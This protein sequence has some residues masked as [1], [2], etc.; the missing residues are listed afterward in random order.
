MVFFWFKE[1]DFFHSSLNKSNRLHRTV[2]YAGCVSVETESWLIL[3]L[4]LIKVWALDCMSLRD[5]SNTK[6]EGFFLTLQTS[7]WNAQRFVLFDDLFLRTNVDI[8]ALNNSDAL[9]QTL[10]KVIESLH[11]YT[12]HR[13]L[14]LIWCVSNFSVMIHQNLS[15]WNSSPYKYR[16]SRRWNFCRGIKAYVP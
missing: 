6:I 14:S 9:L 11:L 5:T 7:N 15:A 13:T 1:D 12:L 8:L 2:F 4:K 3:L 16:W 10:S